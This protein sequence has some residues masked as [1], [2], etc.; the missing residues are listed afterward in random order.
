MGSE[1]ERISVPS[2]TYL[3]HIIDKD[4]IRPQTYMIEA[5]QKMPLPKDQKK[6]RSFLG[7]VN[8]DRFVPGIAT[9]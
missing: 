3:G 7:M 9:K 6:L 2:Y 8:Y 5:I 4:G 1:Y